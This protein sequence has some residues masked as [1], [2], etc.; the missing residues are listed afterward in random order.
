MLSEGSDLLLSEG[1]D[2]HVTAGSA[3]TLL[4]PAE[5]RWEAFPPHPHSRT[6]NETTL[7]PPGSSTEALDSKIAKNS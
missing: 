3:Q 2:F 5:L 6:Q 4:K 1:F 7:S